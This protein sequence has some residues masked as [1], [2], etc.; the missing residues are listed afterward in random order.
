ML[1]RHRNADNPVP[2]IALIGHHFPQIFKELRVR[3]RETG[4]HLESRF[5]LP[6]TFI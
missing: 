5:K 1:R 6:E 4:S 2:I 3:R